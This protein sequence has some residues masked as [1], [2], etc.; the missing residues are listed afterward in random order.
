MVKKRKQRIQGLALLFFS[1]G[2][3]SNDL[4]YPSL[5][6]CSVQPVALVRFVF[7]RF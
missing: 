3:T 1:L 5:D 7:K 4:S 6:E 2:P